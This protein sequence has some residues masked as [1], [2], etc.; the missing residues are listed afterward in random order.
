MKVRDVKQMEEIQGGFAW[1]SFV[2]GALCAAGLLTA[3]S[4][5]GLL[6]AAASCGAAAIPD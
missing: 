6:L 2:A 3:E 1:G 4:G 5:V